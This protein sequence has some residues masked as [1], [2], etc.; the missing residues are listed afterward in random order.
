MR[1]RPVACV[2]RFLRIS[3]QILEAAVDLVEA[4]QRGERLLV[5]RG[6]GQDRLVRLGR[7]LGDRQLL[8]VH[9]RDLQAKRPRP[10]LVGGQVRLALQAVDD[11]PPQADARIQPRQRL[12]CAQHLEGLLGRGHLAV[13][14]FLLGHLDQQALQ[15]VDRLVRALQ[16]VLVEAGQLAQVRPAQRP[17][18]QRLR[19]R[20]GPLLD[21]VRQIL[22]A[23][24]V[25]VESSTRARA[26]SSSDL[27][28]RISSYSSSALS[29]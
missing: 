20:A 1:S 7:A 4:I 12:V 24:L 23:L 10:L 25:P 5:V 21:D 3:S 17:Q 26:T 11:L 15:R 22:P 28:R 9:R 2:A 16:A 27:S 14:A 29:I 8:L 13:A 18:G 6:G 19:R